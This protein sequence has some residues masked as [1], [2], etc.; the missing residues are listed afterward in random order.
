MPLFGQSGLSVV[1]ALSHA[2]AVGSWCTLVYDLARMV[3]NRRPGILF[4]SSE[5]L[6]NPV[7][8]CRTASLTTTGQMWRA[9]AGQAFGTW[10]GATACGVTLATLFRG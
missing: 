5:W 8:V 4:R 10:V 7:A 3:G 1:L 9:R 2:L 6:W